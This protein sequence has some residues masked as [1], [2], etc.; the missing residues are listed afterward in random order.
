MAKQPS[1][2]RRKKRADAAPDGTEN[3]AQPAEPIVAERVLDALQQ[4]RDA[5][6]EVKLSNGITLKIKTVPPGVVRRA[7]QSIKLP[8]VPVVTLEDGREEENPDDPDYHAAVDQCHRERLEA[9]YDIWKAMGTEPL[10]I[11]SGLYGPDDDGWIEELEAIT[12]ADGEPL[13]KVNT[14]TSAM[15][16]LEWLT[17]YALTDIGDVTMVTAAQFSR[18]GIIE[19]E[20]QEAIDFFRNDE[21]RGADSDSPDGESPGSGDND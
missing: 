7:T 9:T 12:N 19:R 8:M 5:A 1:P 2:A 13:V 11:P 21:A 18:T 15:R 3:G 16:Y 17:L 6:G 20:V 10:V 14:A 4:M